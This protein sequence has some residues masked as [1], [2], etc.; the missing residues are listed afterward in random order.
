MRNKTRAFHP[1]PV[2]RCWESREAAEDRNTEPWRGQRAGTGATTML[3]V[4]SCRQ[5]SPPHTHSVHH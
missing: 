2:A 1:N 4:T 5:A 3:V